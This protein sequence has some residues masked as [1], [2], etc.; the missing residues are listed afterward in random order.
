MT[1]QELL[2][3]NA[4]L[5]NCHAGRR[6][7][8]IG[9]GPS[10]ASQDLSHLAGEVT[11]VA[12]WFHNHPL[13]TLIRPGYWVLADPAGWDRPD[14]PFL[15]AINHV[16][17]LNIHTR[18]FVPSAGYQYYSSLN[19]GPLIETHFYHF[20]Y[21]KLDHDVIDFTQPVPPYS[22]NVVLSSLMLAFYMGCDPV[23]F[24]GCDHD[25]LAITKESY[26]NHKEEHFYS[27][28][29]PARYDLEFEWLEFEACMNR[30]RD[31]Y[32]RLAH[33]AR[34]W[35]HNVFN[36]TRGG[37]LEYFPRVEF[38]SLFVPAPAKPAPKAPGLEQRALLEGAMALIDAGNAA[39]ALAIIEE[40]LRRNI[41]Q[42]QRIDGLSLLKAHCLTC[43]GQPREALIWARQDYHCNPGNRDHA[44]PLI[45]RLEA[46]LA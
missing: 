45:N 43:L 14:Q 29:A 5:K 41:N 15:P 8:V 20:D 27:E 9:N 36:A 31:Q 33:Y 23:Y 1:I 4:P 46:L 40:A 6:A 17:S 22:Q 10:L 13:A 38:E 25:F 34:R 18:L 44:L 7:F 24:I 11:I 19:N 26:A 39:A 12:S 28:K 42:S 2:S 21:T 16:K 37:C 30:L 35:G 32:Q 3:K